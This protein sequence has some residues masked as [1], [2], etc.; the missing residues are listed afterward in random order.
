MEKILLV[1]NHPFIR[2]GI[3][4]QLSDYQDYCIVGEAENG[5]EAKELLK[6]LNPDIVISSIVL[7]DVNGIEL[8]KYIASNHVN[9]KVLILSQLVNNEV[10][11]NAIDAGATGYLSKKSD[12][13]EL[14]KHYYET[15]EEIQ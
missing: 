12:T 14:I 10:V 2:L 7:P 11:T 9:V 13:E 6:E 15:G 8:T 4:S 1:D 5:A 3:R